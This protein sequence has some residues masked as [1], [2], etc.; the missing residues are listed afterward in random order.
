M[1]K[2]CGDTA[3]FFR[4]RRERNARRAQIRALRVAIDARKKDSAGEAEKPRP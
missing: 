1:S 4:R 2:T 3:R